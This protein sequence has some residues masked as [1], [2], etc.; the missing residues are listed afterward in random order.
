M[1]EI[2][3]PN[4][5][6][7]FIRFYLGEKKMI[8]RRSSVLLAIISIFIL[9]LATQTFAQ[10]AMP[11]RISFAKGKSSKT[12]T[13]RL[14]NNQEQEF[15]IRARKGQKLQIW[16]SSRPRGKYHSFNVLGIDGVNYAT[17]YDI[18]YKLVT[19]VPETGDYLITV[20]KRPTKRNRT[21]RFYLTV[22]ITN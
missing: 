6:I 18:N 14:S 16:I 4:A 13:G 17:D 19:R 20:Q 9:G 15:V 22:K 10:K 21:A 11:K 3:K 7:N 1:G 8:L 12:V 5:F 2:L